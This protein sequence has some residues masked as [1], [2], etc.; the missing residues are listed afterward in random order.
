MCCID[1]HRSISHDHIC[2]IELE[3]QGIYRAP[4]RHPAIKTT[5]EQAR[6]TF[7]LEALQDGRLADLQ[8]VCEDGRAIGCSSRLLEARWEWFA[9]QAQQTRPVEIHLSESYP[10]VQAFLEYVYTLDLVTPLQLRVPV[11]T[12][13][14]MFAKQ[15]Q[16]DH[17]RELCVHALHGRLEEHTA[18][19]IYEVATVCEERGLQVR[20]LKMVLVSLSA[21]C[22][23]FLFHSFLRSSVIP[24]VC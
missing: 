10:V 21:F 18:L 12:G 20:A 17:L 8:V 1:E 14:L 13:L 6:V 22:P 9:R 5:D 7:A 11:L 2:I 3:V 19:G 4:E 24:G 15:Y 16:V 23:P